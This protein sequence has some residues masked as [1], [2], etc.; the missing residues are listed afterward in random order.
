MAKI[1]QQRDRSYNVA[2]LAYNYALQMAVSFSF[3][4]FFLHTIMPPLL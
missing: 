3:S 1:K 2:Q 4:F